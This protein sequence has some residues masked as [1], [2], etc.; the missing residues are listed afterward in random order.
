MPCHLGTT[1]AIAG[2]ADQN[3]GVR[4]PPQMTGLDPSRHRAS[5]RIAMQQSY[6]VS[7]RPRGRPSTPPLLMNPEI[8]PS[9]ALM[10]SRSIRRRLRFPLGWVKIPKCDDH[11]L[12]LFVVPTIRECAGRRL[13]VDW[14]NA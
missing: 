5:R 7:A 1:T 8:V 13:T 2:P 6:T 9:S 3:L 10:L 12:G 14:L 11:R 4:R